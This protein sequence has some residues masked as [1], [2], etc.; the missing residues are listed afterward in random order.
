MQ[1]NAMIT[2]TLSPVHT[3]AY[4]VE[5]ARE[6]LRLN[7]DFISIKD[8]T[9]LLTPERGTDALSGDGR[10]RRRRFPC[11]FTRIASRASPPRSTRSRSRR[12][13]RHG[14]TAAEPLANG[15]SLPATEDIDA[16]A[17]RAGLRHRHRLRKRLPRCPD[18]SRWLAEREGK[19]RGQIAPYDPALYE[20]QIPGG[21][22][23]NLRSQLA[24]MQLEHRLPEIL[25]EAAQVRRDLGYPIV[26]SPFAQY[27]VTQ[28]MLNVVQG[29]RY[30]T[31]PDEMRK[32]ALGYYGKLA[33]RAF[34]RFSWSAP[35]IRPQDF[36]TDAPA[37]TSRPGCRACAPSSAPRR[38]RRGPAARRL[39]RRQAARAAAEAGAAISVP[40]VPAPR[41]D[42]PHRHP[43]GL[44]AG[45][46]IRFAGT[47]IS[48][49]RLT[50]PAR[51]RPVT[52]SVL[53]ARSSSRWRSRAWR[54]SSAASPDSAARW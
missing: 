45:A 36:V 43:L 42:P 29:E 37:G 50:A 46:R 12:G 48:P 22:I 26:V 53:S 34:R 21:M 10:G 40:H 19:P 18:I 17:T 52:G 14:Y 25:E 39:L 32:Y 5:R 8:P 24:A 13:F 27:I 51:T 11:S 33:A 41:I 1:V 16:R 28:A 31:I 4:Y 44:I 20:H 15:A 2:Y 35:N 30:K 6:L 49:F 47:D 23:S 9:G 54:A 3:D 7:A 38:E